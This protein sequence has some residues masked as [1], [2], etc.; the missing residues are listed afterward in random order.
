[1]VNTAVAL[2]Y[3]PEADAPFIAA[4]GKG[5]LARRMVELAQEHDVP[6]VQNQLLADVLSVQEVGTSIPESTWEVVAKIF[7]FIIK[8]EEQKVLK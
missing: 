6:V 4:S 5:A 1:M 3:P 8:T 7:A 2:R